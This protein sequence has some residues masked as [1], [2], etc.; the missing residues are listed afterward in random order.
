MAGYP[1]FQN[2]GRHGSVRETNAVGRRW[3]KAVAMRTPVPKWRERKRKRWGMGRV[4]K[5]LAMRGKEHAVEVIKW[6][7]GRR[8]W[9]GEETDLRC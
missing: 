5:R 8:E 3:T 9:E 1:W 2:R 6:D 7:A 4:G